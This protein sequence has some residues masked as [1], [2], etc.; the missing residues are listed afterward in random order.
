MAFL[1]HRTVASRA[2]FF[3]VA[4]RGL[5]SAAP[6]PLHLTFCGDLVSPVVV[7]FLLKMKRVRSQRMISSFFKRPNTRKC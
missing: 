7:L 2:I 4:D 5:M 1:S 6:I 3:L